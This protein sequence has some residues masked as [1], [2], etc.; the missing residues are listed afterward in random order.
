VLVGSE[1]Q[2]RKQRPE[3]GRC[4]TGEPMSHSH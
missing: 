3:E 2:R 4:V 1:A